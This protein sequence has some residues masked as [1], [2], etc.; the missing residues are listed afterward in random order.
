L[1]GILH[2][3]IDKNMYPYTWN[4]WATTNSLIMYVLA[5]YGEPDHAYIEKM[6]LDREKM[7]Y[8]GLAYLMKT[9]KLANSDPAVYQDIRRMI[10]NGLKESPTVAYFEEPNAKGLEWCFHSNVRT[11]A[12]IL[13]AFMEL[14]EDFPQ[15]S[16]IVKW[17][18]SKRKLGGAWYNTQ[19]NIYVLHA[20]NT[21]FLRYEGSEP[22]FKLVVKLDRKRV[23]ESNYKGY[24]L[25]QDIQ[26]IDI[27]NASEG[28]ELKLKFDKRGKG[29]YYY[30]TRLKY[31]PQD[32]A[33]AKDHGIS[34]I[35]KW[36]IIEGDQVNDAMI[37]NGATVKVTL[38]AATPMER[39]YI[40]LDDPLPAGFEVINTRLKTVSSVYE[41][42]KPL[43]LSADYWGGFNYYEIK[44]DRVIVF[45]DNLPRGVHTFVYLCKALTPGEY[46]LPATK[47]EE[48]Y[49]PEVFGRTGEK[50]III[51]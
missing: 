34:I 6:Y 11:T 13:Q 42:Y 29:R 28:E 45:A 12:L 16:K 1:K 41:E 32:L 50:E 20:L 7:P 25:R 14:G 17:L 5:L 39:N 43:E 36:E 2:S 15:A 51:K 23:L 26:L 46:N 37:P 40:V 8:F 21:Y 9:L 47:V 48:M 10:L 35:K 18:I 3:R 27:S 30:E 49:T 24:N 22:D 19:E 33:Q 38:T 31:Y 44:D 4:Y